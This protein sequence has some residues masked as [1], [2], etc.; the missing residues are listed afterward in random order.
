MSTVNS[1]IGD[2]LFSSILQSI[3][4]HLAISL[5]GT[6]KVSLLASSKGAPQKWPVK[7]GLPEVSENKASNTDISCLMAVAI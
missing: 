3:I 4:Q 5:K 6:P 1:G 2:S 7:R